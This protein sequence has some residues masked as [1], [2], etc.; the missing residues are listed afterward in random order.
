[1]IYPIMSVEL[2]ENISIKRDRKSACRRHVQVILPFTRREP[3]WQI[4]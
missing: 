2:S 1:M 4:W 3:M